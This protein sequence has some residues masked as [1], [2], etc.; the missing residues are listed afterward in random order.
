MRKLI[1]ILLTVLLST[2]ASAQKFKHSGTSA[3]DVAPKGWKIDWPL[4]KQIFS[5]SF[6]AML[7]RMFMSMSGIFTTR[8]IASLGTINVASN[9]LSLTAESMSFMPAFAFQTAIVTL[10]G[11]SLGAKT[12][13][14][15][16][17]FV[18]ATSLI[19]AS[20][21]VVTSIALYTLARQ[22]IGMFTPD[23]AVIDRASQCL[24]VTAFMQV[25]QVLAWILAGALRGAG[26][27]KAT[28]IITFITVLLVRPG[29]AILMI[30][31]FHWG[32]EGAWVALVC[33]QLLR[34]ILVFVRYQSGKWKSAKLKPIQ[35]EANA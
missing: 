22:I 29:I 6:P 19:G 20:V 12:P 13:T 34:T 26:D 7:E 27:T 31:G 4:T 10:V 14:L 15:A 3:K 33:D 2:V 17:R 8:S 18:R 16:E 30:Y 11:Q 35:K 5:I 1:I 25:P 9:S 32:L 23:A 24:R 21:M 28:A